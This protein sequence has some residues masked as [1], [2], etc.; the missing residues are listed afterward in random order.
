MNLN[1]IPN[2]SFLSSVFPVISHNLIQ[3]CL[4]QLD[5]RN[6]RDLLGK[7]FCLDLLGMEDLGFLVDGSLGGGTIYETVCRSL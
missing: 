5:L 1:L 2:L 4:I 6:F 3:G 7:A